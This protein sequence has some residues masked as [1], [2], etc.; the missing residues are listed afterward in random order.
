MIKPLYCIYDT[1]AEV[2]NK[3][4]PAHNDADATRAFDESLMESNRKDEYVL[5]YL[6]D[7]NDSNGEIKKAQEPL[8]IKAGLEITQTQESEKVKAVK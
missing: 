3:P 5:Y 1:I 8:K 2:F 6:G 7:F 4:F